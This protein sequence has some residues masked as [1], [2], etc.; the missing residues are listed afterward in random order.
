MLLPLDSLRIRLV[1]MYNLGP[2]DMVC[3]NLD[4]LTTMNNLI[5]FVY[6]NYS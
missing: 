1:F 4:F 6:K 5:R 2:P 3:D